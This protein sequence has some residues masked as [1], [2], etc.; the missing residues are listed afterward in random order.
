M[1]RLLLII[2]ALLTFSGE[3]SAQD[4]KLPAGYM[5]QES[6]SGSPNLLR[7]DFD[8]D[9]KRDVFCVIQLKGS[10]DGKLMAVLKSGK[11]VL[12]SHTLSMCCG[13]VSQ[14]NNVITLHSR[15]NRYFTYYKFRWEAQAK[16]FRLIGYD[17]ESFG[18]A[19]HDGSGNS[20]LNML[21][22][23][24]EAEFNVWD[25]KT[26]D[27][28]SLPKVSRKLKL[29]RRIYLRQFGENAADWLMEVDMA[30]RPKELR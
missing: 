22:G 29:E 10:E 27:I 15:G 30:S 18:N 8:G 28:K 16:D 26:K 9:G 11:T 4:P 17:T 23:D 2:L 1:K 14:G 21:T 7:G 24:Y 19:V 20:S 6:A 5:I 13:S 3:I 25:E 12:Y